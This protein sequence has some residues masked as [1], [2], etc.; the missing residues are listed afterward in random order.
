M[1]GLA[2]KRIAITGATGAVGRLLCPIL[3]DSR[4]HVLV[5]SRDAKKARLAVEADEYITWSAAEEGEWTDAVDG[6]DAVVSLAGAP[7]FRKWTPEYRKEA[8]DSRVIGTRGLVN[9]MRKSSRRPVVFV[10]ASSVGIYGYEEIDDRII[11]E[12][13][14]PGKDS[15]GQ[16]SIQW[17]AEAERA[18]TELGVRTVILRTGIVLS[19]NDGPLPWW[20]HMFRRYW[21]GP[22]GPGR[23]WMPWIHIQDE[24]GLIQFALALDKVWG[25]LNCTAP[26]PQT[27]KEF[28]KTLGR[29]L[30]RPSW[31]PGQAFFLRRRYGD[32]ADVVTRS[33]RVVPKKALDL[34]Y[35]FQFPTSEEAFRDLI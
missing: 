10:S 23:Q 1:I 19:K 26:N 29:V 25:P 5:L 18:Q 14:P 8:I 21:G 28:F 34:G 35:K 17:E 4:V 16:D 20:V 11:D 6:C 30:N 2:G 24:V 31:A 13:S 27:S 32:V 15:W 3:R 7:F 9:A 33:K 12:S 22:I